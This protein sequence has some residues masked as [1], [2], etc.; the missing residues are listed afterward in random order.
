MRARLPI[1]LV[2]SGGAGRVE[3]FI[4]V[5]QKGRVDGALAAGVFHRREIAIPAL[6][7]A[8]R[9]AGIEVTIVS[10]LAWDK[11]GGLLPAVVQDADTLQVLM[12]GYMNQEAL[13][14]TRKSRKVTF[15][16][17][18]R[19][20]LWT[21]GETSGNHLDLVRV[22]P[23]CDGDTLLVS[24]QADRAD[25]SPRHHRAASP[26]RPASFLAEL[27]VRIRRTR[28]GGPARSVTPPTARLRLRRV[29]Q[30]VGE[31]AVETVIAA[32]AEDDAALL[33]RGGGPDLPPHRPA[34]VPG[35]VG[36]RRGEGSARPSRRPPTGG[37]GIADRILRVR[38]RPF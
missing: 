38:S 1:P 25:V 9:E 5:F 15:F 24:G 14:A 34:A 7:A 10:E 6:K 32:L 19:N 28:A 11:M 26:R 37:G 36:P 18:S 17:R 30:K 13:A 35:A 3:H 16:S 4:D 8:L 29:A 31:E 22:E 12:L 33:G 23:D 2:A 21:K 20:R 27:D